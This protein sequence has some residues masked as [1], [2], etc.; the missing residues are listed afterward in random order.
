MFASV[1]TDEDSDPPEPPV[2]VP[3]PGDEAAADEPEKPPEARRP[4]ELARF[5]S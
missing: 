2:P 3:G 4:S 5:F 1:N